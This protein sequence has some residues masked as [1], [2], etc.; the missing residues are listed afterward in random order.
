MEF[1]NEEKRDMVKLYYKND[2][3]SV[4]TSEVYLNSYPERRQPHR[5]LFKLLDRNLAEYGSFE[6]PRQKYGDRMDEESK[7]NIVNEV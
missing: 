3:N 2:R 5:T 4:K 1:T 7:E 6:K